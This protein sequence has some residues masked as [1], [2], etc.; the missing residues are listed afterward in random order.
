MVH[1]HTTRA[2]SRRWPMA[3]FYDLLDKAA[4]NAWILYKE[5]TGEKITRREFII[6]LA[7]QL[8]SKITTIALNEQ[9]TLKKGVKKRKRCSEKKCDNKTNM[10]CFVCQNFVCGKHCTEI[11]INKCQQCANTI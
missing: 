4:L 6:E 3:I 11:K 2:C 8:C 9:N 1:L 10:H 5:A 7:R